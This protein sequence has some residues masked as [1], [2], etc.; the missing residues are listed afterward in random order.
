METPLMTSSK[1]HVGT[2]A[3][4]CTAE[5]VFASAAFDFGTQRSRNIRS[6][7]VSPAVAR[8]SSPSQT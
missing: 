1:E 4:A 6:A 3:L 2:G 5:A 7:G 8:A